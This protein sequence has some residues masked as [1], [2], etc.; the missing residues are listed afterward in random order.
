[1]IKYFKVTATQIVYLLKPAVLGTPTDVERTLLFDVS[2]K[3]LN[4][5]VTIMFESGFLEVYR[6]TT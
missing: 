3:K 4:E 6:G 1:M 2:S 5:F